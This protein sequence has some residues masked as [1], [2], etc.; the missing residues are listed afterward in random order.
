MVSFIIVIIKSKKAIIVGCIPISEK[1]KNN[2]CYLGIVTGGVLGAFIS[3]NPL[4][5]L[6]RQVVSVVLSYQ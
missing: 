6:M 5:N 4:K 1:L 3:R 2:M